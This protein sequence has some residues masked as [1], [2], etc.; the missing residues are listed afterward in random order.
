MKQLE[1]AQKVVHR[2]HTS[3]LRRLVQRERSGKRLVQEEE[4]VKEEAGKVG[5]GTGS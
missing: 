2:V 4:E 3:I 1:V 5:L